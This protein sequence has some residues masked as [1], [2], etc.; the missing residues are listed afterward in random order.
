MAFAQGSKVKITGLLA[1][2]ELNNKEATVV[3]SQTGSDGMPRYQ[4]RLPSGEMMSLKPKNLV[5]LATPDDGGGGFGGMGGGMPDMQAMMKNLPPWLK[6]K[7]AR[8][9]KPGFD[10]L[11]RLLGID[12]SAQTVGIIALSFVALWWKAGT[13]VAILLTGFLGCVFC[14][15]MPSLF[16]TAD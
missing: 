15:L 16:W 10:D 12:V 4:I 1:K 8:G 2:P 6:A 9:E 11:K 5:P 7:L 3:S 14:R 13:I